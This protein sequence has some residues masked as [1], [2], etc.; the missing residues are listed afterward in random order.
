MLKDKNIRTPITPNKPYK[1]ENKK[2]EKILD[3]R[4]GKQQG[5]E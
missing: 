3:S 2:I 5:L 4:F 1:S